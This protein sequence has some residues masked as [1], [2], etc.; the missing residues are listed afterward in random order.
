V[1]EAK[2]ASDI[3]AL[4]GQ[5]PRASLTAGH[6]HLSQLTNQTTGK[7]RIPPSDPVA[8]SRNVAAC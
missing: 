5:W 3:I 2:E 1:H 7:I 6:V 8:D 4:F